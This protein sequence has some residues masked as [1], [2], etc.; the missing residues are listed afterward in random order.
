MPTPKKEKEEKPKAGAPA[1][2]PDP[3]PEKPTPTDDP[4]PE[5]TDG[6]PPK[7]DEDPPEPPPSGKDDPLLQSLFK[8]L[9]EE[10]EIKP[11]A[12]EEP[13]ATPDPEKKEGDD[14][15]TEDDA[16]PPA[17]PESEK[18]KRKKKSEVVEDPPDQPAPLPPPPAP[19]PTAEP[20]KPDPD[21]EY[22]A[23]LSDEQ[24]EELVEAR[25]A[26]ELFPDKYKGREKKL[27]QWYKDL[28]S[29]ARRLSE[30]DPARTFDENDTE[31]NKFLKTKPSIAPTDNKRV[32]RTIIEQ[33]V[34]TQVET[35]HK[36]KFDDIDRRTRAIELKPHIE[37]IDKKFRDGLIQSLDGEVGELI[38][39]KG[40]DEAR[41]EFALEANI[42]EQ[43]I[44]E[45]AAAA[46]EY[47]E[48]ANSLKPFDGA[49]PTHKFIMDFVTNQCNVFAQRGGK[50]RVDKQGRGFLTRE[51]FAI[52][53]Q[54]DPNV[55]RKHWTFSDEQIVGLLAINGKQEAQNRIKATIEHAER[56]GFARRPK[57]DS[58]DPKKEIVKPT[59]EPSAIKPPSP[60]PKPAKGA[61]KTKNDPAPGP[62]D[63]DVAASARALLA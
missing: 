25:K 18:P 11:V 43:T 13:E 53:A 26:E 34:R 5:S 22:I 44:E 17:E 35:E 20:E 24:R 38:K 6:D 50:A 37:K 19:A 62:N 9:K 63:I 32:Q 36:K 21:A 54:K 2:Q 31:F 30:A 39:T 23:G 29:T 12:E 33:S 14:P 4:K 28:D 7:E 1:P 51:Q 49:N 56:L 27:L 8:D 40:I 46:R 52:A 59:P 61:A 55:A 48:I 45:S 47:T 57:Q 41:K 10:P 60:G 58:A 15:P 16:D 3:D 42:Y